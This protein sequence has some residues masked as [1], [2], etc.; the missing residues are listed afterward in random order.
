MRVSGGHTKGSFVK[1]TRGALDLRDCEGKQKESLVKTTRG[2]P[3]FEGFGGN[4]KES[5]V[6]TTRGAPD[7]E[8]F[9]P[10]VEAQEYPFGHAATARS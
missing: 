10:R 4:T 8:F 2:A 6:K 7:F 1:T 9:M 3:D 5:L